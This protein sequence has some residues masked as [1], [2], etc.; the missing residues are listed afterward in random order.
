[1]PNTSDQ[2]W[3]TCLARF[4]SILLVVIWLASTLEFI[5]DVFAPSIRIRTSIAIGVTII[6]T[7][8]QD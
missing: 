1:M 6:C 5:I 3:L 8:K 4:R 2:V 7:K